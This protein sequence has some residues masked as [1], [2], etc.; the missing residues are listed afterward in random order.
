MKQT[1]PSVAFWYKESQIRLHVKCFSPR[2]VDGFLSRK[3]KL[4]L[5]SASVVNT[6]IHFLLITRF[7]K[8]YILTTLACTTQCPINA[9][10][11]TLWI[12]FL[13]N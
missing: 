3:C 9:D 4:F 11:V 13:I 12:K 10:Q 5:N 8:T 1:R 6:S 7:S 2:Q